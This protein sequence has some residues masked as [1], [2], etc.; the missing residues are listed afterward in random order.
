MG[1]RKSLLKSEEGLG[2]VESLIALLIAGVASVALISIAASVIRESKNNEMRDAM[3]Q[4]AVQGLEKVRWVA[5]GDIDRIPVPAIETITDYYCLDIDDNCDGLG[6][7]FG[8]IA[9]PDNRCSV[10]GPDGECGK[11]NLSGGGDHVFYREI[12]FAQAG[13]GAVKVVVSVGFLVEGRGLAKEMQVTG[14]IGGIDVCAPV[15][16]TCIPDCDGK[17]CGADGC[18]GSCGTCDSGWN[19]NASW[20]CEEDA[21]CIPICSGECGMDS[22]GY[23]T[24][25]T[26]TLPERCFVDTCVDPYAG[27]SSC[28]PGGTMVTMGDGS[29]KDIV[30]V[31]IGDEVLTYNFEMKNH[32]IQEVYEIENP[33]RE[34]VYIFNDGSIKVTDEHPFYIRK[35]DGREGWGSMYPEKT[36]EETKIVML[37]ELEIGDCLLTESGDWETL[38]SIKYDD[39]L[40]QTYNLKGVGDNS[41]FYADGFLVHNK[42]TQW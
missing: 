41:N 11:L 1:F 40:I 21:P 27:P 35:I 42:A 24:C 25:G 34:G 20:V 32:E 22:C 18:G 16:S 8:K 5:D 19:C 4:Y 38:E 30:D 37:Y 10:D 7:P 14:F 39:G 17:E 2:F 12:G 26:C 6:T 28:F 29:R 9:I 36:L 23:P 3:T 13:C 15:G 33:V 31:V